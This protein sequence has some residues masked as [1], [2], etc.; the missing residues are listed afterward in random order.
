[1]AVHRVR[2]RAP[3]QHAPRG[4][5]SDAAVPVPDL[6]LHWEKFRALAQKCTEIG[7][8]R[9]YR[10]SVH[11]LCGAHMA[12]DK[13]PQKTGTELPCSLEYG[14]SGQIVDQHC[15]VPFLCF[16]S[17][18]CT[19][20]AGADGQTSR[21]NSVHRTSRFLG[22]ALGFPQR[23]PENRPKNFCTPGSVDFQ[24][25]SRGIPGLP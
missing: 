20:K 10:V 19:V 11:I 14:M 17:Q 7:V 5:L 12:L 1:M 8:R 3:S 24:W 16:F 22:L 2:M 18:C 21:A 9:E 13:I 23:R 25:T 15:S 6:I 4:L